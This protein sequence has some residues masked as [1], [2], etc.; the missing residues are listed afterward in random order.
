MKDLG[1][2]KRAREEDEAELDYT[3]RKTETTDSSDDEVQVLG[4][5]FHLRV[6]KAIDVKKST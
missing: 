4:S 6:K 2:S 1:T 5:K 3:K